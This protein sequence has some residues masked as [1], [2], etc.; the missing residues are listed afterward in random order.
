MAIM[1]RSKRRCQNES[2][3]KRV[4]SVPN[5]LSRKPVDQKTLLSASTGN[6]VRML[7]TEWKGRTGTFRKWD[8]DHQS[9]H[10]YE[11]TTLETYVGFLDKAPQ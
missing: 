5:S 11:S 9:Q 3:C 2:S 4:R 10:R 1:T 6:L 8:Y 7:R